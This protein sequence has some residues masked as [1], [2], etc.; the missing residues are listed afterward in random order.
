[1]VSFGGTPWPVREMLHDQPQMP[2]KARLMAFGSRLCLLRLLVL[3][4]NILLNFLFWI[5]YATF[6]EISKG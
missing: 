4:E 3:T 1:M 6:A 5:L 2:A